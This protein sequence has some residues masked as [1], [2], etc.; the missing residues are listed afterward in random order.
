MIR[1]TSVLLTTLCLC[2]VQMSHAQSR[3]KRLRNALEALQ[4]RQEVPLDMIYSR[5]TESLLRNYNQEIK[6]LDSL[7][8][9]KKEGCV[10]ADPNI[11]L[12]IDYPLRKNPDPCK[13]PIYTGKKTPAFKSLRF[14]DLKYVMESF[15]D[16]IKHVEN[17]TT[18]AHSFQSRVNANDLEYR[19]AI[20]DYNKRF[21]QYAEN[22][23]TKQIQ[24]NCENRNKNVQI[25]I[26]Q[27]YQ[28]LETARIQAATALRPNFFQRF[29]SKKCS[30]AYRNVWKE[31]IPD[32]NPAIPVNSTQVT[33]K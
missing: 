30:A 3:I 10:Q 6:F 5:S 12:D 27:Q 8:V 24:K 18:A 23:L 1:F 9:L 2:Y 31:Y 17:L 25:L 28:H 29:F 32:K 21:R 13:M 16:M 7:K 19:T 15:N 4:Q 22:E 14:P 20:S 33:S 26:T 11:T